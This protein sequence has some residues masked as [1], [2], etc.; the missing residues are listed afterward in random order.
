MK[1]N[2]INELNQEYFEWLY[3]IVCSNEYYDTVSYRDVLSYLYG[4]TYIYYYTMDKNR[5][6]DGISLRYRFGEENGYEYDFILKNLDNRESSVLEMMIALAIDIEENIMSD[7]SFGD[8]TGQWFWNMMISLGLG[9]QDNTRFNPSIIEEKITRFMTHQYE[10]NGEGG[11]F[12]IN[13]PNFDMRQCEIWDQ[14]MRYLNE[15]I[16]N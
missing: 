13:D 5:A 6:L 16:G 8:R 3:K 2:L 1:N 9:A 14:A 15:F 4:T 11:L 7:P 10:R 12:I